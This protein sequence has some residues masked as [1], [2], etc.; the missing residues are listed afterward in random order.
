MQ[1]PLPRSSDEDQSSA[2][3]SDP[4]P[5]LSLAVRLRRL[6]IGPPR[7]LADRSL[8]HRM[9][10]V[11]FLAWVGL[12]AD[13]LSSSAY[14]PEEAY[15]ALG[16][17]TY[18][19][20]ALA[21]MMATTVLA[22]SAAY[23]RIIE[24]FPHGG[25]GYV[26]ASR[27]LGKH[28]GVV[29]GSALLVDYVLTITISVAAAGD[30]LFSLLPLAW[31]G[32]KLAAEAA[33]VIAMIVMNL[34]GVRESIVTLA[35][36]FLLFLAT[37]ALL[38]GAGILLHAPRLPATLAA[39]GQG[40]A[41]GAATLGVS[42]LAALLVYAYS[43]GGGTY[44]GIEAVSNGLSIM[45]APAVRT[46]QR[47]MVYM[48]TSL[49]FTATGLLLCYLL[50][51]VSAAPGATFNAVLTGQVVAGWPFG[52][53]LLAAT[54]LSEGAL[55]VV[56]A[57]AGFTD[58]PRVLANMAIDAW[59]PRRLASLS[60]RLTT[61]NGILIMGAAAL[62]ALLYTRGDVRH[63]VVMY[64]INVF[65]TFSLSMLGMLRHTGRTWRARPHGLRRLALFAL[66][67][68]LCV[69][70]VTITIAEK[71]TAGG[72]LTLVATGSVIGLCLLIRRHYDRVAG[73]LESLYRTLPEL[74][75]RAREAAGTPLSSQRVA[76][77]L[78]KDYSG[79]GLHT[80]LNAFK[81]FPN[82]FQGV[83]FLT[84]GVIDSKEFKGED[85]LESLRTSVGGHLARYVEFA[86]SQG[87]SATSRMAT[88]TDPVAE[89]ERLC[90]AAA[91][92][93]PQITF[94]AGKVL[95]GKERWYQRILH[96]ETA[97]AIQKRLQ[98]AGRLLVVVPARLA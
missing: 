85:T 33:L 53:T 52:Q 92:D 16:T 36:I 81:D 84:V 98:Q 46:A 48:G 43:L 63:I 12:G 61:Q 32:W 1:P 6:L 86:R 74:P 13:G 24:Q 56:A 26:V 83:V 3:D 5:P 4:E 96:N 82:H 94:F 39:A 27:L 17:H 95:F 18:L 68:A 51:G 90:L 88:G 77:I 23:S 58:G 67:F 19:A 7:D 15:R 44:T 60:E 29:S 93:F 42:G 9:S 66:G 38:I 69:T 57:Q 30:A 80:F 62:A 35:P 73:Q 14:G 31:H 28:L 75:P 20:L 45:R 50:W 34:R 49:A 22:I 97:L 59:V 78:V 64:S 10:L 47:T 89:A 55:L 71:F 37:H 40:Y 91:R 41:Q 76:G 72:W 21:A 2:P 25:G 8:F 11:A 87:I 65:I 79:L 54:L 70:I